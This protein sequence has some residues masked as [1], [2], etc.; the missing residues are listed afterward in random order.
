MSSSRHHR[1]A[2]RRFGSVVGPF[3][4]VEA[5]EGGAAIGVARS[6]FFFFFFSGGGGGEG[7]EAVGPSPTFSWGAGKGGR[8]GDTK[9]HDPEAAVEKSSGRPTGRMEASNGGRVEK[10]AVVPPPP[11]PQDATLL[12]PLSCV[13]VE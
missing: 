13:C 11:P 12:G 3:A 4:A 7:G 6:S 2:L 8:M 5:G 1:D 9:K 10:E